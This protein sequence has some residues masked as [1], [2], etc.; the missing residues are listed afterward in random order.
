MLNQAN[1]YQ[2]Q[3]QYIL[4]LLAKNDLLVSPLFKIG[5]KYIH[6]N[7]WDSASKSF[8]LCLEV[9][10]SL[11]RLCE[12]AVALVGLGAVC[13]CRSEI[14]Q[15]EKRY[16]EAAELFDSVAESYG[17]GVVLLGLA[18][19][20]QTQGKWAQAFKHYEE[21]LESLCLIEG[22]KL[23]AQLIEQ[24][25]QKKGEAYQEFERS[26]GKPAA[27]SETPKTVKKPISDQAAAEILFLP[28]FS[29]IPAGREIP[30]EED[31]EGHIATNVMRIQ[32]EEYK[33]VPLGA[34]HG[35][36]L[37]FDM[38]FLYFV[39]PVKGY[40]MKDIGI[41]DG[42]YVI[43][44][45]PLYAPVQA[46]NEDIVAA[47]IIGDETEATL[48][49]FYRRDKRGI[50]LRPA[51]LDL[52]PYRFTE[53]DRKVAIAGIAVAVLKRALARSVSE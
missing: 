47:S 15:A 22:N 2:W 17:N 39:M 45:R 5:C 9:A 32:D 19:I 23:A 51:N 44:R 1:N 16:Q 21:S 41:Q 46:D 50:E 6:E 13:L 31:I 37:T 14:T 3:A 8:E 28:I 29:K 4:E 30:I 36:Q 12:R 49:R 35:K 38:N 34:G 25:Q 40:S 18:L 20:H 7:Q 52:P 33:V 11:D 10:Q 27:V 48:K 53:G 24:I 26:L 43:L 42:D